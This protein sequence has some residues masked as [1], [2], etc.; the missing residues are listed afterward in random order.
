VPRSIDDEETGD[1]ELE[2]VVLR[3]EASTYDSPKHKHKAKMLT[4]LTTLVFSLIASR[5]K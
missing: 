4:L 1:L 3:Q 5:G 2:G